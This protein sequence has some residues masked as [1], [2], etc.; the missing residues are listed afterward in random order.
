M[1]GFSRIQSE[2]FVQQVLFDELVNSSPASGAIV[3]FTGLVR[4]FN[5]SGSIE[6]IELEHYPQM[7][8]QALEQL[9]LDALSRFDLCAAAIVHRVGRIANHQQI[10][11]VGTASMHRQGA[12]DAAQYM[13]DMLKKSVPLWKKEW[14]NGQASWVEAKQ[15]D[16]LAAMK[17]L[18]PKKVTK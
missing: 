15:A 11:W 18:Q 13:M 16:E 4:D 7:A 1:A 5:S 3:T 2:D 8:Q 9:R 12:F 6:G 14:Q 17:W 10:V